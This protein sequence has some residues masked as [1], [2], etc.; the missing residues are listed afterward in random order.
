MM[1]VTTRVIHR[2]PLNLMFMQNYL[3]VRHL[4]S[5]KGQLHLRRSRVLVVGVGGLGCPAMAYLAGAGVGTI[6]LVD[7]D[8][9][10]ESNLARQILHTTAGISKSKVMSA[11][12]SAKA[13][14]LI[15][16]PICLKAGNLGR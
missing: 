6:G 12:D 8:V 9:V 13:Y 16:P 15:F 11:I 10:E 5:G 4:T 7:G 14:V 1:V 3:S 2:R